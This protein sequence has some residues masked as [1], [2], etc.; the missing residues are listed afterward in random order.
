MADPFDALRRSFNPTRPRAQFAVSLRRR[1]LEELKMTIVDDVA[2]TTTD[3][4]RLALVHL[5][6]TDADRAMAFFGAL[7]GWQAERVLYEGHVNHYTLNT[8]VTVRLIGD[9]EAVPVR[10]NYRVADVAAAVGAI[11]AGGGRV[12]AS[13][14]GPDGGGWAQGEDD[15]GVP[16]LVYRPGGD[17]SHAA[18]SV[19]PTGDVGLVFVREDAPRAERFYGRVLGWQLERSHP[20]SNYFHTVAR[21]GIF[22]E[23]AAFGTDEPASVSFFVEVQALR[24]AVAKLEELG[25]TAGPVP[26]EPDMGPYFSVECTDDQGTRFGLIAT[27]LD[28]VSHGNRG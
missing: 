26:T 23:N 3:H 14:V 25:G 16:L 19:E 22:D 11:E 1:I 10:P 28:E 4:G 15:Q 12:T 7:F 5:G 18:P 20:A 21:V 9:P 13:E 24:P 8:S 27:A 17:Y 2:P 6:V